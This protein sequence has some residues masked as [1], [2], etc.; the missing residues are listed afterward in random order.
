MQKLFLF[1]YPIK[2]LP[3]ELKSESIYPSLLTTTCV[4][5]AQALIIFFNLPR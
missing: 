4:S 1:P 3:E 5:P 2:V